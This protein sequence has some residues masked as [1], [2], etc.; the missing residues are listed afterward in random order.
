MDNERAE[1]ELPGGK[2][3]DNE[4]PAKTVKREVAEE[5]GF[6]IVVKNLIDAFI[7]KIPRSRDEAN[8][9]LILIY[10]CKITGERGKYETHDLDGRKIRFKQYSLAELDGI[11]IWPQYKE[12]IKKAFKEG[13]I[14][15]ITVLGSGSFITSL[16]HFGPSYLIEHNGKRMLVDAGEGCVIQLLK[17]GLSPMDLNAIFITHFHGDHTMDLITI[18]TNLMLVKPENGGEYKHIKIYGQAGINE[19]I[20]GL[21]NIFCH[22]KK[23]GCETIELSGATKIDDFT[24]TPVPLVHSDLKAVAYRFEIEGKVIVFSGD[25]SFCPGIIDAAKNADLFITDCA[26][27]EELSNEF[28]MNSSEVAKVCIEA[29]VKK[30]I[31]SH[32]TQAVFDVD[33]AAEVKAAG[34][35]GEVE[36]AKDFMEIEL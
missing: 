9:V 15:K 21:Y 19:F 6:P 10:L 13:K 28:H 22:S 32:L 36:K 14:M 30:V 7:I 12:A 18:I 25:C 23:E 8:G 2:I 3:E 5:L 17:L 20:D 33:L 4:Q 24:V 26:N 35:T 27:A 1:W 11:N 34:F 16:D 31:L 29:N